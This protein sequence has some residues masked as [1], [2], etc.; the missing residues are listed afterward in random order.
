MNGAQEKSK[1]AAFGAAKEIGL[2]NIMHKNLVLFATLSLFCAN[3]YYVSVTFGND[4]VRNQSAQIVI[5]TAVYILQ[6][7]SLLNLIRHCLVGKNMYKLSL[8]FLFVLLFLSGLIRFIDYKLFLFVIGNICGLF[9][10]VFGTI[11]ITI[12]QSIVFDIKKYAILQLTLFSLFLFLIPFLLYFY[13]KDYFSNDY[14]AFC[15]VL[16][17]I[18]LY[19]M[20]GLGSLA[21]IAIFQSRINARKIKSAP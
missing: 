3:V 11:T 14:Y 5:F 6:Y 15:I 7:F 19:G 13:T 1:H 10:L 4:L 16:V 21:T 18:S 8:L 20:F 2:Q 17:S 12:K 9:S